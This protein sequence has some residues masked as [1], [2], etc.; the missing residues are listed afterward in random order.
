MRNAPEN[1][2]SGIGGERIWLDL[3]QA[4]SPSKQP[5]IFLHIDRFSRVYVLRTYSDAIWSVT[6]SGGGADRITVQFEAW[7][8]S[9]LDELALELVC[10]LKLITSIVLA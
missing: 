7:P 2:G 8:I 9:R 10:D 6:G 5:I 1:E 3:D 4:A